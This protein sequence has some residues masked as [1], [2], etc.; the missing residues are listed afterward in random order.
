MKKNM[1]TAD[2]IIR[3]IA[4]AAIIVLVLTDIITG[5]L[6][7]VFLVFAG[8]LVLTSIISTCPLYC[9]FKIKTCKKEK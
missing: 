8:I 6:G 4:A 1:G 9:P 3:L 5:T 7:I 2:R